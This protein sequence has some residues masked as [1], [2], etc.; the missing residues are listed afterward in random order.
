MHQD[1]V[2]V[3]CGLWAGG[4]IGTYFFKDTANSIVILNGENFRE[5][6]FPKCKSLTWMTCDSNKMFPHNVTIVLWLGEFGEYLISRIWP[7]V[8]KIV[9]FVALNFYCG[10]TLKLMSIQTSLIQL[11]HW[12][13]TLA[14]SIYSWDT[15]TKQMTL[16]RRRR[17]E[18]DIIWIVLLIQIT[19]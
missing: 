19:I 4:I 15:R 11:T 17:G 16:L 6:I 14:Q 9:R 18:H 12:R 2:T 1:K 8:V 10:A 3:W 7:L 5:I 13:T